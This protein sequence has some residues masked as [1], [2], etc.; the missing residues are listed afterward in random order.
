MKQN[1]KSNIHIQHRSTGIFAPKIKFNTCILELK[2]IYY[3]IFQYQ[4]I[5]GVFL[6][7]QPYSLYTMYYDNSPP[8][9][10]SMIPLEGSLCFHFLAWA[11]LSFIRCFSENKITAP[12]LRIGFFWFSDQ[13]CNQFLSLSH[14][15]FPHAPP[16]HE[17]PRKVLD[18]FPF[19]LLECTCGSI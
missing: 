14:S 5:L 8:P 10:Q 6:S 2:L 9:F 12:Q 19:I 15:P 7:T 4:L 11:S 18:L 13:S 1:H 3:I 17:I 16:A